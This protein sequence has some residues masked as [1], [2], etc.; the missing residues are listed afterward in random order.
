MLKHFGNH[1]DGQTEPL[2][3]RLKFWCG[4]RLM[5][6][7]RMGKTQT[8]R[9]KVRMNVLVEAKSSAPQLPF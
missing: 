9:M 8:V 4:C 6:D 1:W 2:K 7:T 3:H 5:G